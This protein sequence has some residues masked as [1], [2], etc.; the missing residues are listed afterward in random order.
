[1][2]DLPQEQRDLVPT[3]EHQGSATFPRFCGNVRRSFNSGSLVR[4]E[5]RLADRGNLGSESQ[6]LSLPLRVSNE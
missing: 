2:I 4:G 3:G 6:G 5:L 1:V